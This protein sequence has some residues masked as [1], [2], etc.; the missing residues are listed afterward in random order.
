MTIEKDTLSQSNTQNM[1]SDVEKNINFRLPKDHILDHIEAKC[2]KH[3]DI[4]N[5]T[6]VLTYGTVKNGEKIT[7]TNLF[8]VQCLAELLQEFQKEG[9]IE[10]VDVQQFIREMTDEEK[11]ERDKKIKELEDLKQKAME[12]KEQNQSQAEVN[13]A[14]EENI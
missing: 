6:F 5:A 2:K 12:L 13:R 4:T 1:P 14:T 8:C 11:Q 9:K 10:T 3:G 7:H